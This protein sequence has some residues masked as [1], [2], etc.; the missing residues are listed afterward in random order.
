M[1]IAL[2]FL[3]I[4][5]FTNTAVSQS[6][7]PYLQGD[8]LFLNHL[9]SCRVTFLQAGFICNGLNGTLL[10]T[11]NDGSLHMPDKSVFHLHPTSLSAEKVI[12]HLYQWQVFVDGNVNL[13]KLRTRKNN[14]QQKPSAASLLR[15][16]P[17]CLMEE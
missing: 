16:S 1:K 15:T 17:I 9:P 14:F 2:V 13:K 6:S 8:T 4:F 5:L 10:F 11:Y 7:A 3:S 12:N